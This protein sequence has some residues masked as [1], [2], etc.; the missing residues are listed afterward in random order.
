MQIRTSARYE[1]YGARGYC[2]VHSQIGAT[3]YTFLDG[4][5]KS[6]RRWRV[7]IAEYNDI[8]VRINK[9]SGVAAPLAATIPKEPAEPDGQQQ[10]S[11][12]VAG[13]IFCVS[14][15]WRI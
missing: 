3:Q 5:T 7:N 14:H 6:G 9:G 11:A 10:N 2:I 13:S 4:R 1:L 15:G 8:G 12:T